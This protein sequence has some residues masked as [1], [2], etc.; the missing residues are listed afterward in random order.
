MNIQYFLDDED[1]RFNVI[2]NDD[3]VKVSELSIYREEKYL[4]PD[5]AKELEDFAN[6]IFTVRV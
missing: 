3:A 4:E 1:R 5:I 6:I 2:R